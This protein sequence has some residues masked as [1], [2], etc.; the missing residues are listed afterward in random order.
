MTADLPTVSVV[1]PVHNG[2]DHIL[3]QLEAV[4]VSVAALPAVQVLV[5][6]N[7]S[8]D[9]TGR[10]VEQWAAATDVDVR[11]VRADTRQGEPHAR[12]VGWRATTSDIVLFCD[13]DDIVSETWAAAL[14][15]ALGGNDYATGPLD[16][17]RIN[18]PEVAEVRGQSLFGAL[19]MLHDVVPFAHGA[20]MAFRRS[21]LELLGGFDEAFLIGCDIEIAV[22]AWRHG[23]QLAW[24]PAAVVHYRLRSSPSQ[25]YRQAR[26]YGLSRRAIDAQVPELGGRGRHTLGRHLRR[27]AWLLRHLPGLRSRHGRLSWLWV[28]GQVV[29]EVRARA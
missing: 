20:N 19:P 23:I 16:T 1:I 5:V 4:A 8:T 29:G 11:L 18:D 2:A 14:V 26:S 3:E 17:R 7:R 28:A 25:V 12:N 27:A 10:V 6:D 15:D 24:A 9:G 21:A 13:A 22:R